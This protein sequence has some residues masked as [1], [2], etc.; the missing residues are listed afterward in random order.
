MNI[1][2]ADDDIVRYRKLRDLTENSDFIYLSNS[3]NHTMMIIEKNNSIDVMLLECHFKTERGAGEKVAEQLCKRLE[4]KQ[5]VPKRIILHSEN[6]GDVFKIAE[7]LRH[8][9]QGKAELII[10]PFSSSIA[11][12]LE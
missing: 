11:Q 4:D 1:L 10:K 2:L 6:R 8:P 9:I 3:S 12:Y 7:I 5:P